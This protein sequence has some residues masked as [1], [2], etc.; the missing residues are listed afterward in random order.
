MRKSI[1][2]LRYGGADVDVS[3]AKGPAS[4]KCIIQ[5]GGMRWLELRRKGPLREWGGWLLAG[6]VGLPWRCS[7]CVRGPIRIDG[8]RTGETILRFNA[9]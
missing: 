3:S 9:H 6:I 8:G 4:R 7:C 5:D 2:A 1:R